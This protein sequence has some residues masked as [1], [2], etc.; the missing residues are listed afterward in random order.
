MAN[1]RRRSGNSSLIAVFLI[2]MVV[3]VVAIVLIVTSLSRPNSPINMDGS[4]APSD[5]IDNTPER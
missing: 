2:L 5:V 3:L 4:P 1:K